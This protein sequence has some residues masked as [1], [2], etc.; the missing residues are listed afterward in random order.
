[1]KDTT[2]KEKTES[3]QKS[4][5]K[6]K[7]QLKDLSSKTPQEKPRPSEVKE[8]SLEGKESERP[9]KEKQATKVQAPKEKV[10]PLKV[11][12]VVWLIQL[13]Q[14]V[15]DSHTIVPVKSLHDVLEMVSL[16]STSLSAISENMT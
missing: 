6:S 14:I 5:V 3:I 15:H 8:N 7:G 13:S 2:E 9:L 1:M 11:I 4:A 10:K 12:Y 16:N